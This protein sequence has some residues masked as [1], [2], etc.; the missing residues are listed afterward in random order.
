MGA[1]ETSIEPVEKTKTFVELCEGIPPVEVIVCQMVAAWDKPKDILQVIGS[2]VERGEI[3]PTRVNVLSGLVT[4]PRKQ[5]A[6]VQWIRERSASEQPI[7]DPGWRY[8]QRARVVEKAI[9]SGDYAA[10]LEALRDVDRHQGTVG[11]DGPG[12]AVQ[13]NVIGDAVLGDLTH[14]IGALS[15][16]ALPALPVVEGEVIADE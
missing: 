9:D 10:A 16:G 13:V 1:A 8:K 11:A 14:R 15:G 4:R 2:A 3:T 5:A 7:L 6:L 12:A